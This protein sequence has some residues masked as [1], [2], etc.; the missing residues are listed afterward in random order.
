MDDFLTEFENL[1]I[2]AKIS[3]DHALEI[4]QQ[5]VQWEAMKQFIYV[6]GPPASYQSLVS[7]LTE[8]GNAEIYLKSI[9][10]PQFQPFHPRPLPPTTP[11]K[12]LP[13]EAPMDVD[14]QQRPAATTRPQ[15]AFRGNCYNCGKEG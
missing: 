7:S 14:R 15:A 13:Q 1:K 3:D 6:Y 9:R 10:R 2:L 8:I 12:Q 5:N 4:L 11:M